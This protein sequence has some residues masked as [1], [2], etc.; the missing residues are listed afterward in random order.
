[1]HFPYELYETLAEPL[2][3]YYPTGEEA[4]ARWVFQTIDK[5]AGLLTQLLNQPMPEIEILLVT[6]A[7]WPLAPRNEDEELSNPQPYWTDASSPP[8]IVIPAEIDAIFGE[9]TQEKFAYML[10][11]ELILAFLES[12]SRPWPNDYPLWADEWQL[13][14]AALWLYQHLYSRQDI[15]NKDLREQ[16]AEIFEPE[17]D[18]KTPV[19]IRGFDWYEDTAAED[20]LAYELL[21]EQFAADLLA[22]YEPQVLPRFLDLYRVERDVL[23]SDDVTAMLA[24]ALGPGGAEWLEELVYF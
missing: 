13:K 9:F 2:T 1:M 7:D 16:N 12:D 3:V 18:G 22:T 11:H 20:Y 8:C 6:M 19:T 23:L 4:R 5:A 15:V 24:S 10:C 17:P 21:L 14:F